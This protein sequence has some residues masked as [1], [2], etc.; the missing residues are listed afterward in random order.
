MSSDQDA[1]GADESPKVA[2]TNALGASGDMAPLRPSEMPQQLLLGLVALAFAV[3][4]IYALFTDHIWE[5]SFI[6]LRISENLLKGNGLTFNPPGL[7]H[8]FTSPINVLLLAACSY[9]TGQ[10]S[11]EA[12]FWLYR[13]FCAAA[14]AGGMALLARRIWSATPAHPKLCTV[15]FALLYIFDLKMVTFTANGMETAFMLLFFAGALSQLATGKPGP[16]IARGLFWAGMMWTRPD[17]CIYIAGMALADLYFSPGVRRE[18]FLSLIKSGLLCAVIYAPWIAWATWYYGS[19]IPHTVIAKA[20]VEI[21]A[22]GQIMQALDR[23]FE[24]TTSCANFTFRPIYDV[25]GFFEGKHRIFL[26]TLHSLSRAASLFCCFYWLCP[27][28]DRLGRAA[29]LTFLVSMLYLAPMA[30]PFPWYLA[31]AALPGLVALSRGLVTLSD[32]ALRTQGRQVAGELHLAAEMALMILV[33]WQITMFGLNAWEMRI[34]Q[35]EVEMGNRRNV[36]VWLHDHGRPEE[37]IL[38]EPLGYIGYFSQMHMLDW[39]GLVTPEMVA[40]RKRVGGGMASMI[41]ELN[42]DWVVLR[43]V[44]YEKLGRLREEFDKNYVGEQVFDA[45]ERLDQYQFI[46]GKP[47]VYIDATFFVFRRRDL[48]PADFPQRIS[49]NQAVQPAP[50]GAE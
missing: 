31:F 7:V 14:F 48:R 41:H 42:P 16:G 22:V 49:P 1:I 34:Q 23:L 24:L 5:D 9:V 2:K 6:T 19:P 12:T 28:K 46:P 35:T 21:G 44:E 20:N 13:M 38:L 8:G 43:P 36:G 47:Y 40:T 11:Y 18:L 39:P 50:A 25:I 45:K 15:V 27:V 32:V 17:G 33:S 10:T 37:T 4:L 26:W 29:S 30:T 3:P